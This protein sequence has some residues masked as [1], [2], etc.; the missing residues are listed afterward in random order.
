LADVSQDR[1]GAPAVNIGQDS[2]RCNARPSPL[3][4]V[5]N[6]AEG[7]HALDLSIFEMDEHLQD[8]K[9]MLHHAVVSETC[10]YPFLG[11]RALTADCA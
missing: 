8:T 3:P 9:G 6:S 7:A 11:L 2:C 5:F 1:D 10:N 4:K